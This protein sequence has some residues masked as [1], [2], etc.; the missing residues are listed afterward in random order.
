MKT[1]PPIL[2]SMNVLSNHVGE[3][4]HFITHYEA[5]RQVEKVI[6][7]NNFAAQFKNSF[8]N[9]YY[10][11]MKDWLKNVANRGSTD[12]DAGPW[13]A[14]SRHL[15]IGMS[16]VAMGLNVGTAIMQGFGTFTTIDEIGVGY[17]SKGL[18]KA[19]NPGVYKDVIAM[20]GEIR[21][22]TKNMDREIADS[23]NRAFMA[24]T[25]RKVSEQVKQFAFMHIAYAQ[26]VVNVAAF[27][28]ARLKALDEG[29]SAAD[30]IRYAD[31]VVRITQSGAGLKDLARVQGGNELMKLITPF[32]TYFSVLY[33]RYADAIRETGTNPMSWMKFSQRMMWLTLIPVYTEIMMKGKEPDEEEDWLEWF[34]WQNFDYMM[35]T[36]P[37]IRE[38][39]KIATSDYR[40][41]PVPAFKVLSDMNNAK[42]SL[43]KLINE[44]Y[45]WD[46][47]TIPQQRAMAN[48]VSTLGHLPQKTPWRI[49]ES[50]VDDEVEKPVRH[51]LMGTG[52]TD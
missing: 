7:D 32:Y 12:M 17:T 20:S 46:D 25:I 5:V 19:M 9:E 4:I 52:R 15:R 21:H 37:V 8:G 23:L 36:V 22:I 16:M 35:T 2:L 45:D 3:V 34:M 41:E 31:S 10:R 33:N 44:G 48:V 49:Y 42:S 24:G 38:A 47:L 39:T 43:N 27:E 28:G 6:N 11:A 30:S 40:P 29:R 26:R 1:P 13:A 51:I 14:I 50:M 18:V